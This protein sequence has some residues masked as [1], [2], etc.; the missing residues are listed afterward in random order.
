MVNISEGGD[1]RILSLLAEAPGRNL[2][3][4]HT[5]ADHNRSVFTLSG[6]GLE[7]A[8]QRLAR[9][10][11]ELLD[12]RQHSGAHPRIGVID[13]VPFVPLVGQDLTEA[14][15][16]RDRFA[17][18][19][20][21]EIGVPCYLYGPER[22][23]PALRRAAARG[24]AADVGTDHPRQ[25]AGYAA[26]GARTFLVAYNLWLSEGVSME[27][28]KRA[29]TALRSENVRALAFD[30]RGR[31]QL[32][33]NLVAPHL[34]GPADIY[35]GAAE[36]LPIERAELVG[37]VPRSVL[38]LA[39]KERWEQLDLSPDRTIERRLAKAFDVPG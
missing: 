30:L 39:P 18:W 33:F 8:V 4:V 13:V 25:G 36:L 38:E 27:E 21:S 1:Q 31:P 6:E 17:A 2:L 28:A 16:A 37:L 7:G 35:D 22:T 24:E 19:A 12:I 15:D 10:A 34:F 29:A 23:L 20:A 3:D 26:V 14:R 11:V 5:D 9:A 32:S